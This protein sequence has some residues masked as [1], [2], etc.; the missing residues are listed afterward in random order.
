MT[1]IV[2]AAFKVGDFVISSP[3]PS[4]HHDIGMALNKETGNQYFAVECG[5]DAQGFLTSDGEFVSRKQA[6][7]IACATGQVDINNR[8]TTELFTEDLW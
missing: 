5:P 8:R 3:P 4:R 2:A 7:T 1:R 6:M